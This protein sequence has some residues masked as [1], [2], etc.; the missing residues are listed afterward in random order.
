M[1]G[2]AEQTGKAVH[3]FLDIMRA[4]PLALALVIMNFALIG[5][6]YFQ[7]A[8]FTSQRKDNIALFVDIQRE[9]QKLLSQCIVPGG[10]PTP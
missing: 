6:V 10:T 1:T 3:S 5:F 8:T 7:S 4:Q 9:V 2:I